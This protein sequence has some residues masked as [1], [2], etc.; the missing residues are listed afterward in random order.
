M[1]RR[2]HGKYNKELEA[3]SGDP[4]DTLD[5]MDR[6]ILACIKNDPGS[7]VMDVYRCYSKLTGRDVE[8][9]AIRYRINTLEAAHFII[10]KRVI[11]H[12][13]ERRCYLV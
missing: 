9:Q 10:T 11:K 5:K 4:K 2:Q 8:V 7:S 1:L 3:S 12:W 6:D 13:A